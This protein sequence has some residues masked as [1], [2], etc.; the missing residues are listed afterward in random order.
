MRKVITY[1]TVFHYLFSL[2]E[3]VVVIVVVVAAILIFVI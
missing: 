1:M 2:V 3:I